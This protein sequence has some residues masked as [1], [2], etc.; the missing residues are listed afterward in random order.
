[1]QILVICL[2]ILSLLAVVVLWVALV[3]SNKD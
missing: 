3:K 2:V 1:M